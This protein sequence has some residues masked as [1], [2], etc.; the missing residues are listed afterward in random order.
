[1]H[2]TYQLGITAVY[3]GDDPRLDRYEKPEARL[4]L[5]PVSDCQIIDTWNVVGMRGSGSHDFIVTDVFVPD[6]H[7]LP[8]NHELKALHSGSLY[9]FTLSKIG[10][11][12]QRSPWANLAAIGAGALCLGIAR[13]ALDAM[14]ELGGIKKRGKGQLHDDVF[15]QDQVGRA[16]ATLRSARAFL[17]D[18]IREVWQSVLTNGP[19]TPNQQ[20][21]LHLAGIHA[22]TLSAQVVDMAWQAAGSTAIFESNPFERRFRDIHVVTQHGVLRQELYRLAGCTFLGLD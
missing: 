14:I 4:F 5:F 9:E 8:R 7:S 19:C 22:V 20:T 13:G 10:I 3:D 18:T 11:G 15:F 21:L 17:Y 2:S 16:E 12:D 6:D 1:M